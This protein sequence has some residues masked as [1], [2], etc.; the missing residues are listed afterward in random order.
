VAFD[1]TGT[2]VPNSLIYGLAFNTETWGA[3][4]IGTSGP[5]NSLNFGLDD[6]RSGCRRRRRSGLGLLEARRPG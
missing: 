6:V 5:Y 1:F 3:N 4:P 2:T